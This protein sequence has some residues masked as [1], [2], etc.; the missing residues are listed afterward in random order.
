MRILHIG[1]YYPPVAGGMERFVSDLVDTQRRCGDEVAVLVHSSS[2][3][4]GG[5]DPAWLWRCPV[6]F[7]LIFAPISP[8]FPLWLRRA[9]R[10]QMPDILHLHMPNLS[11]F[12]ALALPSARRLPW[13]VHW[14][15]DVVPSKHKLGLRL[16][17]PLY[18]ILE[19]YILDRADVVVA[20]SKPSLDSSKPLAPWH[21]KCRVVPLGM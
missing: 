10:A 8:G 3:M 18:R 15:A 20:T 14:H 16:A 9:I 12:W 2:S 13:V 5:A 11:A 4:G 1:K 7:R 17:Y 21:D 6:W 19:R